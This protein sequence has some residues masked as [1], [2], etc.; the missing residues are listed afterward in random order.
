MGHRSTNEYLR[1]YKSKTSTHDFQ[2][3]MHGVELRDVTV[4]SSMSL[5]LAEDAPMVLP[6]AGEAKVQNS[7]IVLQQSSLLNKALETSLKMYPSIEAARQNSSAEYSAWE[8]AKK[9]YR[10][11]LTTTCHR[12]QYY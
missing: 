2:A 1:D 10:S 11:T 8:N 7:D 5:G 3:M 9:R 4:L 12:L 6:V